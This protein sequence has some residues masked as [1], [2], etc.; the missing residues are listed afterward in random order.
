MF[1]VG[2]PRGVFGFY[3]S[4]IVFPVD[5]Y[6]K[7][8]WVVGRQVVKVFH[9]NPLVVYRSMVRI[10]MKSN[11]RYVSR[12]WG[13]YVDFQVVS[14]LSLDFLEN[15]WI[16]CGLHICVFIEIHESPVS[17]I[18]WFSWISMSGMSAKCE[19]LHGY[20]WMITRSGGNFHKKKKSSSPTTNEFSQ[21]SRYLIYLPTTQWFVWKPYTKIVQNHINT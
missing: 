13:F 10:C 1:H 9:K 2:I 18:W 19:D 6:N 17:W 12:V 14:Y 4:V 7:N 16:V 21:I 8:Q 15:R 11:E 20:P 5:S 3:L